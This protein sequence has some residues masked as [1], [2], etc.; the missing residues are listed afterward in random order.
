[1][2]GI[3]GKKVVVIA[4]IVFG[5]LQGTLAGV[6]HLSR[7]SL[8]GQ[9]ESEKGRLS[10]LEASFQEAQQRGKSAG[11]E[12]N[13]PSWTLLA[14]P[15]VV[16]TLQQ[17]QVMGDAFGV[18]F[19]KQTVVRSADHG[20]QSFVLAGH[21]TPLQ[22]ARFVSAVELSPRLMILETGRVAP[23]GGDQV[24]FEFGMATY[25]GEEVR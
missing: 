6:A 21:A 8:Q 19:D 15:D 12:P 13:G 22:L 16:A 14:G 17:L 20:K 23:A 4:A 9:I 11:K 3:D 2:S 10:E 5:V 7:R 1:M 24:A 25:H 18:T